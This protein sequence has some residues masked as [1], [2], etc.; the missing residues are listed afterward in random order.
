MALSSSQQTNVSET[1]GKPVL[2]KRRKAFNGDRLEAGIPNI[3]SLAS[4]AVCDRNG[5]VKNVFTHA[6]AEQRINIHSAIKVLH[7]GLL[8]EENEKAKREGREFFGFGPRQI[9]I[10]VSSHGG[11]QEHAAEVVEA[12]RITG[13]NENLIV[14]H[15]RPLDETDRKSVV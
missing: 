11:S 7:G 2:V 13:I 14:T 5:R 3:Q 8:I 4:A 15:R 12:L 10:L 9:A 6:D 1:F